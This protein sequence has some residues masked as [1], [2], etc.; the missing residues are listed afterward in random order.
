MKQS[1]SSHQRRD[2]LA[3]PQRAPGGDGISHDRIQIFNR[4]AIARGEQP[5]RPLQ[6]SLLIS[7]PDGVARLQQSMNQDAGG[8][9]WF[10][11]VPDPCVTVRRAEP[12]RNR[13]PDRQLICY[14][15]KSINPFA[16]QLQ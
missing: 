14:R 1:R 2:V 10:S 4:G 3:R 13:A 9:V 16:C 5:A 6:L 7:V 15:S 12:V 11:S 8:D